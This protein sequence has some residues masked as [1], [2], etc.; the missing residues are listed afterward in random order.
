MSLSFSAKFLATSAIFSSAM[1]SGVFASHVEAAQSKKIDKRWFEIEVILFSQID[2]KSKLKEQFSAGAR[3]PERTRIV[4]MLNGYLYPELA[5]LKL[6]LPNCQQ[7]EYEKSLLEQATRW[8][9]LYPEKSLDEID[10]IIESQLPISDSFSTDSSSLNQAQTFNPYALST[11]PAQEQ[12]LQDGTNQ[13]NIDAQGLAEPNVAEESLAEE[14]LVEELVELTPEQIALIEQAEEAFTDLPLA[15]TPE[16]FKKTLCHVEIQRQD[17]QYPIEQLTGRINGA[18]FVDTDLP[19]LISSSSLKLKDIYLQ[20]RRS[21]NFKPLLH[22]GWRQ[23]LINRR[24]AS[25]VKSMRLY[26]GDHFQQQ[27]ENSLVQYEKSLQQYNESLQQYNESLEQSGEQDVLALNNKENAEQRLLS[28]KV[29]YI[30][31][32]LATAPTDTEQLIS[33]LDSDNLFAGMIDSSD[34]MNG[35]HVLSKP[36]KPIMPWLLD[37]L[38]RVHL[39]HYLYITAD[40]LVSNKDGKQLA[41]EALTKDKTTDW[42]AIPFA[43]N[44]RVISG[45]V[46]YFDHPYMGMVVQIRRYKKPAPQQ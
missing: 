46:H 15:Y 18:E 44:R 1:L 2:D 35:S 32:N 7:G 30:V 31:N 3:L 11:Q 40:F 23:S 45:E 27:Y 38:F 12:Q 22:V 16:P 41:T 26:A 28:D 13:Q 14:G 37:G 29:A 10:L 20:L 43:Q 17:D 4:D 34:V 5:E 21:K 39:N 8:P 19:Y 33:Q 36:E 9:E 25:R 6:Q 42:L 24:P